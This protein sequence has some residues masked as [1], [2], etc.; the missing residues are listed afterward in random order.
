MMVDIPLNKKPN[1][2]KI[3]IF[4]LNKRLIFKVCHKHANLVC[5]KDGKRKKE[6]KKKKK[7]KKLTA[8]LFYLI[9][10]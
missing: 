5:E 7:K 9:M 2:L 6:K 8:S 10:L 1:W 3:L 4:T